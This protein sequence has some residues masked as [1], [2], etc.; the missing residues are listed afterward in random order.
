M[1]AVMG[2]VGAHE[3]RVRRGIAGAGL[4]YV[5]QG[6]PWR[7]ADPLGLGD[8]FLDWTFHDRIATALARHGLTW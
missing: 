1:F 4:S 2:A 8:L 5:R 6:A 7:A 3:D